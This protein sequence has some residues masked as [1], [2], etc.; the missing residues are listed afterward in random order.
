MLAQQSQQL[1]ANY[2]DWDDNEFSDE[3]MKRLLRKAEQ[4]LHKNAGLSTDDTRAVALQRS[5]ALWTLL[6]PY[7][8]WADYFPSIPKLDP[9]PIAQ[10]YIISINGVARTDHRRLV[11]DEDRRLSN[12]VTLMKDPVTVRE[13][14]T[15]VGA[16]V[17]PYC[18]LW[19]EYPNFAWRRYFNPVLGIALP[20]LRVIT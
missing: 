15:M 5:A 9:Q 3:E 2:E 8:S 6:W 11:K 18:R 19:R 4:R 12:S 17:S 16:F 20:F 13:K 1:M 10:P 7:L 14:A